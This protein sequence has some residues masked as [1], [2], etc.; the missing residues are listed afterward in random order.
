VTTTPLTSSTSVKTQATS[1]KSDSRK[2]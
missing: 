1:A 2:S